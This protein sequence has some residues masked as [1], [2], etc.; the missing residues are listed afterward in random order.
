MNTE[1][2]KERRNTN[3]V[4]EGVRQRL[5]QAQMIWKHDDLAR[6]GVA[7]VVVKNRHDHFGNSAHGLEGWT[8]RVVDADRGCIELVP[9]TYEGPGLLDQVKRMPR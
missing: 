8:V 4:P 3:R 9:P 2:G 6:A 5:A 7:A 1:K